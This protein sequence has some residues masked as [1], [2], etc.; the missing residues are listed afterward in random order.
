[1]NIGQNISCQRPIS[2]TTRTHPNFHF[3]PS[4]TKGTGIFEPG[5]EFS[6]QQRVQVLKKRELE[7]AP[8]SGAGICSELPDEASW[9][10][11]MKQNIAQIIAVCQFSAGKIAH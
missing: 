7:K 10:Y 2:S 11:K 3:N 9:H 8:R 5:D 4:V 6:H 1:M